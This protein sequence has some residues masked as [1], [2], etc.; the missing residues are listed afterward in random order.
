MGFLA[1]DEERTEGR[2]VWPL[3]VAG[4]ALVLVVAAALLAYQ[5]LRQ[6]APSAPETSPSPSPAPTRPQTS[7]AGSLD[8]TADVPGASV[9]VDGKV[10]GTAPRIAA[11]LAGGPHQVRIELAG[12]E[13]WEQ[14]AHVIPNV[15]T[16]LRAHLV[17]PA[18]RLRVESDVPGASVFV[19]QKFC[20]R[21]PLDLPELALGP[22]RLSVSAEGYDMYEQSL[23]LLPGPRIVSVAFK[24]VRLD[25]VVDVVHHHTLGSCSGRLMAS[26]TGLRYETSNEKDAFGVPLSAIERIDVDYLGKGLTVKVRGGRTYSFGTRAANA[27]SLLVFQQH[28]ERALRQL[29]AQAP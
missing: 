11:G 5:S 4:A 9:A 16:K 12:Y 3:A 27:D 25:D 20:G 29:A 7:A 15:T 13:R 22:H 17:R 6:A 24:A 2:R 21:T 1:E 26:A 14:S 18:A 19:D 23:D 28:V 10:L 8:I